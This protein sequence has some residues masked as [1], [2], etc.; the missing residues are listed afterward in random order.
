[1]FKFILSTNMRDMVQIFDNYGYHHAVH[2]VATRQSKLYSQYHFYCQCV[3]CCDNWPLY[4]D[5]PM[6]NPVIINSR[7]QRQI[8][9]KC[10]VWV[11]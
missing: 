5:L 4:A 7:Y 11:F 10:D 1:M 6:S 3:A 8:L 9:V 2:D